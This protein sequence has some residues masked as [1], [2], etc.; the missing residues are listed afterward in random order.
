MT[1]KVIHY[2]WFGYAQKPKLIK[3]CIASWKRFLPDFEIIEWNEDNFD[4]NC[5][6]YVSE[7]YAQ[8]KYAF[9]SD[10]VR[11]Y[12]L[13]LYGGLY[14]DTDVEV[15]KPLDNLFEKEAFAGFETVDYVNPGLVLWAKNPHNEIIE[16]MLASYT[17]RSFIK[18]DGSLDTDTVCIYFTK[19]LKEYGFGG[20]DTLQVCGNFTL[21]PREYFCP[22]NNATGV[23]KKTKNTYTIHWYAKSWLSKGSIIKSK[24]TRVF[25]R[26]FGEH[27]F[28]WL[29]KK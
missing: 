2:C 29:K 16:K 18:P 28:D 20:N 13:S 15:I 14:F 27:C 8:K 3:K 7:A 11:F 25:H 22:F 17:D 9:V 23:L 1:K 4:I 19:V 24:I 5:N 6:K 10:Y 12:V 21:Y 26:F